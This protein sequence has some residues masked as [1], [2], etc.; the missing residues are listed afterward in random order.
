MDVFVSHASEDAELVQAICDT[1]DKNGIPYWVSTKH[2]KLGEDFASVIPPAIAASKIMLVVLSQH[3]VASSYVRRE[4]DIAVKREKLIIP[5]IVG[6]VQMTD[7]MEFYLSTS[8]F[9]FYSNTQSFYDVLLQRI[10]EL[11]AQPAEETEAAPK[12]DFQAESYCP[13]SNNKKWLLLAVAGVVLVGVLVGL[14]LRKPESSAPQS[15]GTT[16]ADTADTTQALPQ[17]DKT[18]PETTVPMTTTEATTAV[19]VIQGENQVPEEYNKQI[20]AFASLDSMAAS[21]QTVTVAAGQSQTPFLWAIWTNAVTYSQNTAIATV[22][23][24]VI[25]GVAPGE[26]YVVCVPSEGGS[27]QVMKVIVTP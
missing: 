6:D 22:D 17:E 18:P 11:T 12:S 26:T 13:K 20:E 2:I 25:Q 8:Q 10:Q 19:P 27:P 1:F 15:N 21:L 5:V 24:V 4:V 9:L 14:L 23:G 7:S 3:A 16:T